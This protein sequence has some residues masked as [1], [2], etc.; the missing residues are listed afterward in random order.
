MATELETANKCNVARVFLVFGGIARVEHKRF[1]RKYYEPELTP[2]HTQM[3]HTNTGHTHTGQTH[4]QLETDRQCLAG[5]SKQ[6][7]AFQ[8]MSLA[9]LTVT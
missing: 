5:S 6:T 7:F 2:S 9:T 3:T 4:I 8:Q 1:V